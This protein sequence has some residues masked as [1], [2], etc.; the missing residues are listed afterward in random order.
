VQGL[1]FLRRTN[2]LRFKLVKST[3]L[4]TAASLLPRFGLNCPFTLVTP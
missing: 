2:T 3:I 4:A 1:P